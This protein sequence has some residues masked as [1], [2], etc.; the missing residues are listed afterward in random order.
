MPAD[1]RGLEPVA[2]DIALKRGILVR[3]R[4]TDKATGQPV[5]RLSSTPILFLTIPTL[6]EFPG[7]V[8]D[9]SNLTLI[10][11][12]GRYE[13]VALPGRGI[14]ACLSDAGRYRAGVG[15]DGDQGI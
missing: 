7:Y 8:A 3:G 15:A 10:K 14:I 6:G 9:P 12:D 5:A 4:V 1:S 11:D 2:F 13:V